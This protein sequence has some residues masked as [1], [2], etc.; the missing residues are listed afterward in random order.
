MPPPTIL[1]VARESDR[2]KQIADALLVSDYLVF[3]ACD[4]AEV[5]DFE[6]TGLVCAVVVFG[7]AASPGEAA[8]YRRRSVIRRPTVVIR[9]Y[10]DGD[11]G[12]AV[13]CGEFSSTLASLPRLVDGIIATRV[14]NRC[15]RG[16]R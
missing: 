9:S 10:D 16:A 3:C 6:L 12:P 14:E 5:I 11:A 7:G 1:V 2:R 15:T 4:T 8:S 13:G